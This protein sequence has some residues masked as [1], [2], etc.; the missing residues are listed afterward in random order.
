MQI[1]CVWGGIASFQSWNYGIWKS[2]F[3]LIIEKKGELSLCA[4]VCMY[5]YVC[6]NCVYDRCLSVNVCVCVSL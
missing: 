3:V 6:D 1:Q 2:D 5:V 4:Y